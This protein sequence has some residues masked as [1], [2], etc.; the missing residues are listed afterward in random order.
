MFSSSPSTKTTGPSGA[1]VFMNVFELNVN[2]VANLVMN[3]PPLF[4]ALELVNVF[5]SILTVLYML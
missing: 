4:F 1:Y 3:A 2:D 5:P